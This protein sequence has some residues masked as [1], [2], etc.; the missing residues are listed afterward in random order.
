MATCTTLF[1]NDS[2]DSAPLG[3]RYASVDAWFRRQMV[4][5]PNFIPTLS[6]PRARQADG[7]A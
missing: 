4:I 5:I 3:M 7:Q 2:D 6:G 1:R